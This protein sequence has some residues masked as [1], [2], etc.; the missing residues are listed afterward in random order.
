MSYNHE[1]RGWEQYEQYCNGLRLQGISVQEDHPGEL[2]FQGRVAYERG[3]KY[4]SHPQRLRMAHFTTK[5]G[6]RMVVEEWLAVDDQDCDG[7]SIIGLLVYPENL[8]PM[9]VTQVLEN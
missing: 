1:Y 6:S 9:M 2:E 5:E 3:P 4:H 7:R 8:R